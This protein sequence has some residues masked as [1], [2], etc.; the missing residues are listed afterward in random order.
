MPLPVQYSE[1]VG[2]F[3]DLACR[4]FEFQYDALFAVVIISKHLAL[5]ERDELYRATACR[6]TVILDALK[7]RRAPVARVAQQKADR[8]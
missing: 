4:L 2:L 7:G 8:P 5:V 1:G 6:A 3:L